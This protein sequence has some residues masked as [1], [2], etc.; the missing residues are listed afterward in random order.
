MDIAGNV[1]GDSNE[2]CV[3]LDNREP[4]AVIVEILIDST[5]RVVR[6]RVIQSVP[7]LDAALENMNIG[8]R[9]VISGAISQ[10][11]NYGDREALYGVKNTFMLASKRLRMEGFLVLD[12]LD[13]LEKIL[14]EMEQWCLDGSLR[15]QNTEVQGLENAQDALPRLFSGDHVGK[16]VVRVA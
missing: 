12:Y 3:F 2:L 9:L 6:A 8:G 15:Y 1:S 14:P 4:A 10:Y 13:R 7:M 11:Q 5:G 16:L